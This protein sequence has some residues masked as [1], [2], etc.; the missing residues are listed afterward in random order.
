MKGST[1]H[2]KS[3]VVSTTS[4]T[5]SDEDEERLFLYNAHFFTT[6][7]QNHCKTLPVSSSHLNRMQRAIEDLRRNTS[8][9]DQIEKESALSKQLGE[10]KNNSELNKVLK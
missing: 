2:S 1:L 10:I 6:Y 4:T 9:E 3:E 5:I 7:L 8:K